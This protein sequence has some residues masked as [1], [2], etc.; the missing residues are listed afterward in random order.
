MTLL[1][2][3]NKSKFVKSFSGTDPS[4]PKNQVSRSHFRGDIPLKIEGHSFFIN[5]EKFLSQ[6]RVLLFKDSFISGIK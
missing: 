1:R 5:G 3:R 4:P 6:R 2:A